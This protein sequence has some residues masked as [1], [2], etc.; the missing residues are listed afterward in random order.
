M[1]LMRF[2]TMEFKRHRTTDAQKDE[3]ED[4]SPCDEDSLEEDLI[5]ELRQ[6]SSSRKSS[7]SSLPDTSKDNSNRGLQTSG[8]LQIT[9]EAKGDGSNDSDPEQIDLGQ[10]FRQHSPQTDD[11]NDD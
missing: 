6:E 10:A 4:N 3:Q 8:S 2:G 1:T 11:D 7:I 5:E 9:D